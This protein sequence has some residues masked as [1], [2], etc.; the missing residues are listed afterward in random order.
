MWLH[1]LG[2]LAVYI[3][4]HPEAVSL[5]ECWDGCLDATEAQRLCPVRMVH[6]LPRCNVCTE[7]E[8]CVQFSMPTGKTAWIWE[9]SI[10]AGVAPLSISPSDPLRNFVFSDPMT[11]RSAK[12]VCSHQ[13]ISKVPLNYSPWLL[14]GLL[15]SGD[16]QA[17]RGVT[18]LAEIVDP[19][20]QE[21]VRL[22]SYRGGGEEYV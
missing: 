7:R 20:H 22:L 2:S 18:I 17:R 1:D 8:A 3:P 4:D 11:L 13:E 14:T 12:G 21:S 16:L 9:L 10:E 5:G 15:V 19:D 6:H